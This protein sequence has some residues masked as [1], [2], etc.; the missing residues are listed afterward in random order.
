MGS[1]H[2]DGGILQSRYNSVLFGADPSQGLRVEI[3]LPD[4]PPHKRRYE[5]R[6]RVVQHKNWLLGQ[7][8]LFEDGGVTSHRAGC[9]NVYRVGKGLCAHTELP[10]SYHVLQVSDLD[11]FADQESFVAALYVPEKKGD[12]VDAVTI[13]GDRIAVRLTDMSIAINDSPRPHPPKMLHDC[14]PMTSE[15]GSGKITVKT[16]AGTV[17]FDGSGLRPGPPEM[18]PLPTGAL[19]WGNPAADGAFTTVAHTRALGGLSPRDQGMVLKAVS[20]LVPRTSAGHCYLVAKRGD[21]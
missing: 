6:G 21:P 17:T 9:W 14:E 12:R 11:T 8:A 4:V 10:D 20:V 5:A 13:D 3:L 7:G 1:V 2:S 19:R 16:K 18:A 15:Y